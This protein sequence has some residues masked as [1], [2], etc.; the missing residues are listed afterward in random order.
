[1]SEKLTTITNL[2]SLSSTVVSDFIKEFGPSI[3]ELVIQN[4]GSIEKYQ[5]VLL[6]VIG[7]LYFRVRNN[8]SFDKYD[9]DILVYTLAY[10]ALK[11]N[12]TGKVK[13]RKPIILNEMY[14]ERGTVRMLSAAFAKEEDHC[15]KVIN[16][17]GEPGRTILRLSFFDGQD[18]V[19]TAKHVHFESVEQLNSRRVKLLDRCIESAKP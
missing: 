15:K 12:Y 4:N 5:K 13:D 17:M 16:E 9:P 8:I 18:D 14:Y 11:K 19:Q 1:M 10:L 2:S 3:Q 7:E 6:D